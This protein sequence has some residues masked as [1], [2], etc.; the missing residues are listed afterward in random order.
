MRVHQEFAYQLANADLLETHSSNHSSG[1]LVSQNS[2]DK[3]FSE[4]VLL[5][6]L[7]REA[8]RSSA[9]VMNDLASRGIQPVDADWDQQLRQKVYLA[10]GLG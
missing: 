3:F 1:Q 7:A 10:G 4:Y 9:S 2:I 5:R 8:G 6:D